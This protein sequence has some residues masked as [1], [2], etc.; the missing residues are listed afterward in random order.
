M[1]CQTLWNYSEK[2]TSAI[3]CFGDEETED[4]IQILQDYTGNDN[5]SCL[6]MSS[7]V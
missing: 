2:I 1:I 6:S 5:Y 3:S 7:V 4:L